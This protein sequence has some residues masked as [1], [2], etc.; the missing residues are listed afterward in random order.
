MFCI[1]ELGKLELRLFVFCS[2]IASSPAAGGSERSCFSSAT[3]QG[4]AAPELQVSL[5]TSRGGGGAFY[6]LRIL[7]LLLWCRFYLVFP[8][9][10]IFYSNLLLL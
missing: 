6:A 8:V 5:G 9:D 3:V 10:Y 1:W 7:R 4:T 2:S